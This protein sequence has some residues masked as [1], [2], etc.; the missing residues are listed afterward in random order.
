MP[1]Y[2]ISK[3]NLKE[4]FGFFGKKKKPAEIQRVIDNDP[5]LKKIDSEI[6]KIH[7]EYKI[8]P[9]FV[10]LLKKYGAL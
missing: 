10:E 3:K 8:D 9:E 7:S 1:K 5:R 6:E 4:F 2:K